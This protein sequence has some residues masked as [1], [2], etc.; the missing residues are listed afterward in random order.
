MCVHREDRGRGH[1]GRQAPLSSPAKAS[2]AKKEPFE[3]EVGGPAGPPQPR[4]AGS[5]ARPHGTRGCFT[6]GLASPASHAP[7]IHTPRPPRVPYPAVDTHKSCLP[8]ISP[9]LRESDPALVT[10]SAPHSPCL[11]PRQPEP[12]TPFPPPSQHHVFAH[13]FYTRLLP[14]LLRFYF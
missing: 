12:A 1:A 11:W 5:G 8:Q 9:G 7:R 3:A 14:I 13:L 6:D 10:P 4:Q 2:F